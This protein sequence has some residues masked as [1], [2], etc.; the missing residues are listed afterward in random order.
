MNV[1]NMSRLST[2]IPALDNHLGG[3]L[4]PG[5]LTVVV[6]ATGIGKTQLGLQ[7][8]QAGLDQEG[9]SGIIFDMT[10]RGD[11]QSHA[12][13]SQRMFSWQLSPANPVAP[14]TLNDFFK[15]EHGHGDFFC[16]CSTAVAN[17]LPATIWISTL[18][19]SGA[20]N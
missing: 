5:R 6:G 3:G 12:E 2:G 18:G 20:A 8:A 17:G 11:S 7:F 13:Y 14:Q 19:T 16:M 1:V 15:P 9:K 10:A 4:L